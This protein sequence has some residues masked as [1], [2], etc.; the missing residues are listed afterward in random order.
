MQSNQTFLFNMKSIVLDSLALKVACIP[1]L[2][3]FQVGRV[4]GGSG[5]V[6]SGK[7][8]RKMQSI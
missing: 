5:G 3:P 7:C 1:T 2:Y 6:P 8:T 4:V